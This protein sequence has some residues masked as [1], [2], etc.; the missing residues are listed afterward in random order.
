LAAY[1]ATFPDLIVLSCFSRMSWTELERRTE[2]PALAPGQQ[3]EA[4]DELPLHGGGFTK[5][6]YL[7]RFP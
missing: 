5:A 1:H 2:F 6:L 3:I 7:K 4:G